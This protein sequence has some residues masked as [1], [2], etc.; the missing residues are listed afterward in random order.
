[1]GKHCPKMQCCLMI[2]ALFIFGA[3]TKIVLTDAQSSYGIPC[4]MATSSLILIILIIFTETSLFP[5]K[6]CFP[7]VNTINYQIYATLKFPRTYL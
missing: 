1:M 5:C 4:K 3:K 7:T 2:A 6:K